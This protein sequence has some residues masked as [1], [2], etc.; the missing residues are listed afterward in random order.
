MEPH[1]DTQ[2]SG[3]SEKAYDRVDWNKIG[4]CVL[5]QIEPWNR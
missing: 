2:T 5:Q 3:G 4:E 1:S